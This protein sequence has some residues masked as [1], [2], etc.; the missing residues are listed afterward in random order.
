MHVLIKVYCVSNSFHVGAS[1]KA[2]AY[3]AAI[4]DAAEVFHYAESLGYQPDILDIGGGFPGTPDQFH[5]F[6]EVSISINKILEQYFG[7]YSN[8]CIIAEPG[9]CP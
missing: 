6:R 4:R 7:T 3:Q 5:T 2:E 9:L 1:C 8:L